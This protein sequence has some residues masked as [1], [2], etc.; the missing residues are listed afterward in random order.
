MGLSRHSST[1]GIMLARMERTLLLAMQVMTL[2]QSSNSALLMPILL[3]EGTRRQCTEAGRSSK[4]QR[5]LHSYMQ[6]IHWKSFCIHSRRA[7]LHS[8][9]HSARTLADGKCLATA[10]SGWGRDDGMSMIRRS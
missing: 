10:T 1:L 8:A 6:A 9:P 4:Q 7:C 2:V 5:Q 3:G